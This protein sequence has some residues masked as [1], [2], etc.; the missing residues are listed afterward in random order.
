MDDLTLVECQSFALAAGLHLKLL[1]K[2]LNAFR[3]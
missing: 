3:R 1:R 2:K